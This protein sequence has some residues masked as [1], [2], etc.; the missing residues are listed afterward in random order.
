M[1]KKALV[2]TLTCVIL[3]VFIFIMTSGELFKQSFGDGDDVETLL[4][5][6]DDDIVEGNWEKGLADIEK[7][8]SAWSKIEKRVQFSV[9]RIDIEGMGLSIAR[10]KGS[11]RGEN[12]D[13]SLISLEELKAYWDHLE[14]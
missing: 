3:A 7:L 8:K 4:Q 9:E 2:L 13:E 10:L 12:P 11:I 1:K 6:L 5:E 14:K